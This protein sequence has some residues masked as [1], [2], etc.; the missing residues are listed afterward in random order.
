MRHAA[1]IWLLVASH[2]EPFCGLN[3]VHLADFLSLRL[4]RQ[5]KRFHGLRRGFWDVV[6]DCIVE[7][8]VDFDV[9]QVNETIAKRSRHA[10]I[11]ASPLI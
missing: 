4:E 11:P 5:I 3:D 10:L 8:V 7:L 2:C 6:Q 9:E 1:V